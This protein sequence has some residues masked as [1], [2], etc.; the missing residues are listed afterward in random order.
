MSNID[1]SVI[2]SGIIKSFDCILVSKHLFTM[3]NFSLCKIGVWVSGY[4]EVK[5]DIPHYKK[6]G[7]NINV[8]QQT[9]C[10]VVNPITVCYFTFLFNC[11]SAGQTS[12]FTVVELKDLSI[13]ERARA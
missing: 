8:L 11:T 10:L 4:G 6:I 5:H 1:Y 7:Y 9:T 2:T 3:R 12:D 13:D